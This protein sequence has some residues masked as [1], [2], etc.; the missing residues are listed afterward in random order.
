MWEGGVRGVGFINSPLFG[1]KGYVTD[2][3]FHVTDWL[4]TLIHAAGGD[5][6]KLK[7]QDGFDMFDMLKNNGPAVRKELLHNIDPV[8]NFSS[9]RVGDFKLVMGHI[10][11]ND[12]SWYPPPG[13][14]ENT[15]GDG[16]RSPLSF[17]SELKDSYRNVPKKEYAPST[18]IKVE[19]GQKP[20][21]ASF[22][23]QP[24]KY[25][26]LYHMPSDPCEFHNIADEDPAR[27][28]ELLL[29]LKLYRDT[30]VPP[31]VKPIDPNGNPSKHGGAWVPWR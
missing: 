17:R 3:L 15:G 5:P 29:R 13:L 18:P 30:M 7:K 24:E 27:L 19:C 12:N 25:P 14:S 22:N 9:I 6:S 1:N 4:P 23:C 31:G 11:D 20:L 10:S 16:S 28:V 2:N 21:D 8:F 26:C